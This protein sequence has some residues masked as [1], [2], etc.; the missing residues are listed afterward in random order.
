MPHEDPKREA[1]VSTSD[2]NYVQY[3]VGNCSVVVSDDY[4]VKSLLGTGSYGVVVEAQR[5]GQQAAEEEEIFAIKKL[6]LGEQ[7]DTLDE[8]L[9]T[10]E[11]VLREVK[12][13]AHFDHYTIVALHDIILP[14]EHDL[15]LCYV[16]DLMSTDLGCILH[17]QLSTADYVRIT[18]SADCGATFDDK[19]VLI[20]VAAGSAAETAG[21]A[22]F[23]G[24]RALVIE[25]R[26]RFFTNSSQYRIS[27]Q[28]I[29]HG[30]APNS[31]QIGFE[32]EKQEFGMFS[33]KTIMWSLLEAFSVIHACGVIHRDAKPQNILLSYDG[34]VKLCDFGLAR[35]L[36]NDATLT[37]YVE[38]RWY[39]APELLVE[40]KKYDSKVRPLS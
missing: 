27:A 21:F 16:M 22:P 3:N 25:N 11:R 36:D 33:I 13:L 30:T 28:K 19:N 38:T 2:T 29:T 26:L 39:R 9:Q 14:R 12:L 15:D 23:V 1:G 31:I 20:E 35:E 5:V 4:V 40:S 32:P 34:I 7:G 6:R 17:P 18:P 37:T 10:M 24:R 8:R